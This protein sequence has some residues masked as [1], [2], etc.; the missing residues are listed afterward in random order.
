MF[1]VEALRSEDPATA[2]RLLRLAGAEIQPTFLSDALEVALGREDPRQLLRD[3][4]EVMLEQDRLDEFRSRLKGRLP[5]QMLENIL[6][7]IGRRSR[8]TRFLPPNA[9]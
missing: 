6:E 4:G 9:A 8:R 3:I 7:T 2:Y 1:R 5:P